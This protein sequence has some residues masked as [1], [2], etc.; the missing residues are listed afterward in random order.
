VRDSFGGFAGSMFCTSK[1]K[2]KS[3]KQSEREEL[4][5]GRSLASVAVGH[6]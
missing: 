2:S 5:L 6:K 1:S 4:G 3:T